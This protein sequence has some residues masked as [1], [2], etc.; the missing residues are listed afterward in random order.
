MQVS[1]RP[2]TCFPLGSQSDTS[3]LGFYLKAEA[4]EEFVNSKAP[5]RRELRRQILLTKNSGCTLR[6]SL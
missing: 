6:A 5:W 1:Q 4:Q 3:D 2:D